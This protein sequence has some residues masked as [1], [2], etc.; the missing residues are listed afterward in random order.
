[1]KT[2]CVSAVVLKTDSPTRLRF[3]ASYNTARKAIPQSGKPSTKRVEA[4]RMNPILPRPY[5]L[6]PMIEAVRFGYRT[7]IT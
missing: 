6:T 2:V 1:V 4:R 5:L 3:S 7:L